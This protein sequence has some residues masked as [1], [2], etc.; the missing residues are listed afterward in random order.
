MYSVWEAVRWLADGYGRDRGKSFLKSLSRKDYPDYYEQIQQPM[1]LEKVRK[2]IELLRYGDVDAFENDMTLIFENTR[3]FFDEKSEIYMDAEVLQNIFWQ[4]FQAIESTERFVVA[5]TPGEFT[6]KKR[7]KSEFRL[8]KPIPGSGVVPLTSP[9]FSRASAQ[10]D[11]QQA[12]P[13]LENMIAVWNRI[14]TNRVRQSFAI[15]WRAVPSIMR[16]IQ[17]MISILL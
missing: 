1:T 10:I 9:A 15:S 11:L 4:A 2:K 7:R 17:S 3:Q 6:A 8:P 16:R 5:E 13:E 12:P 14:R